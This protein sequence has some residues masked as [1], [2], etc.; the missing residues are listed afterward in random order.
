MK[1]YL[2]CD[3]PDTLVG[4]RLAGVEGETAGTQAAVE[5]AL[6]R[7]AADETIAMVLINKTL[8]ETCADAVKAFRRAHT[9]PLLVE[10]PDKNGGSVGDALAAYIRDTV[11]I[12]IASNEGGSS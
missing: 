5:Q 4:M 8:C 1:L 7:L 11:G 10:I 2:I 6:R 9:V 3:N 12:N